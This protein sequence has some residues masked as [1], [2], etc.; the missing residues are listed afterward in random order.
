[1]SLQ[2]ELLRSEQIMEQLEQIRKSLESELDNSISVGIDTEYLN[3]IVNPH[4]FKKPICNSGESGIDKITNKISERISDEVSDKVSDKVVNQI[5][6]KVLDKISSKGDARKLSPVDDY[7]E[8]YP[9]DDFKK[10]P[11]V[12][13]KSP[14]D[15]F[16]KLSP[17]DDVRKLSAIDSLNKKT[18]SIDSSSESGN[19]PKSKISSISELSEVYP[20]DLSTNNLPIDITSISNIEPK[21]VTKNGIKKKYKFNI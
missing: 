3:Y 10:S 13:F 6:E 18:N 9:F 2:G 5:S 15:D 16:K 12:D 20:D 17:V 7:K 19:V 4:K 8:L 14:L 21:G 11:P 1:M